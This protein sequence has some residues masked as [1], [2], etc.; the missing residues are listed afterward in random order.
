MLYISHKFHFIYFC[1]TDNALDGHVIS[2]YLV[3][4]ELDCLHKCLLNP[5]CLS[6]NFQ[7]LTA[8]SRHVCELNDATRLS[9][10]HGL[11]FCDGCS[12]LEPIMLPN[13]ER[14]QVLM[15]CCPKI[16]NIL[17]ADLYGVHNQLTCLK[18]RTP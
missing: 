8:D 14:D 18:P 5:K 17:F 16:V 12:Y 11:K 10:A 7:L 3:H 4:S 9:S 6:F 2:A 15:L 1:P 13:L